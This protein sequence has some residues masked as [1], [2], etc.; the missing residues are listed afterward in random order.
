MLIEAAILLYRKSAVGVVR[1][2]IVTETSQLKR[3]QVGNAKIADITSTV[4]DNTGDHRLK[5]PPFRFR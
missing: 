4:S 3:L 1:G 2:K 5:R